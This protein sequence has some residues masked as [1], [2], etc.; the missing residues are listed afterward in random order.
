MLGRRVTGKTL[1]IVGMGRI[2]QAVAHRARQG[3]GM[4]VTYWSRRRLS[5]D[6][7]ARLGVTW[8]ASR[9]ALM[10]S[11]DFVTVHCPATAETR[12]LIDH[13]ALS[14]MRPGAFLVN[15][16]RGDVVDEA[17]LLVALRD[18]PLAG[19][20]LDVFDGEPRVN[21]A[22]LAD[23]RVVTLPHL[24]SAT[25]ESRVAMGERAL[26]NIAAWVAGAPLPDR[27]A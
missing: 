21:P 15:T 22:L 13:A 14:A 8:C 23:P 17:A 6:M 25:M 11:A 3:F 27:V 16:A 19:A 9:D 1:G 2:G 24:G 4:A 10:G 5:P 18:G 20:A 7:E 12:H 26:A